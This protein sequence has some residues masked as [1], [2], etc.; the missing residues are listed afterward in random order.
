M[1]GDYLAGMPLYFGDRTI[2]ADGTALVQSGRSDITVLE[3]RLMCRRTVICC[4][5]ASLE[6]IWCGVS[7]KCLTALL[8]FR[9]PISRR[10]ADPV[11]AIR[12]SHDGTCGLAICSQFHVYDH[13]SNIT[14]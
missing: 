9:I 8:L 10:N 11:S 13:E 7:P 3:E 5:K 6:F 2:L 4:P 14:R 1:Y 12:D